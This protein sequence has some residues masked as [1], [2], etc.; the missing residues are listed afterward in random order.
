MT[1]FLRIKP[2]VLALAIVAFTMFG[3]PER[4]A[5]INCDQATLQN[6]INNANSGDTITCNAGSW[7]WTTPVTVTNKSLRIVGA[8][9]DQ[10]NITGNTPNRSPMQVTLRVSDTFF[11]S[12]FTWRLQAAGSSSGIIFVGLNNAAGYPP[13]AM[14][15]TQMKMYGDPLDGVSSGGRYIV[16]GGVYGVIDHITMITTT[17]RGAGN[18]AM[19]PDNPIS[20]SNSYH[21]PIRLGDPNAL[22]IEDCDFQFAF[23]NQ[24]NGAVDH[25]PGARW[26][27]RRNT[28]RNNNIGN[29]GWDSGN[30]GTRSFEVYSNTFV[31]DSMIGGI[32]MFGPRSGTGMVWDNVVKN[33]QPQTNSTGYIDFFTPRY[34]GALTPYGLGGN[35]NLNARANGYYPTPPWG[36][37]PYPGTRGPLTDGKNNYVTGCNPID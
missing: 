35:I 21:V 7:V 8:G 10:T 17:I 26:V 33:I 12:G 25:Y 2:T 24:G 13:V 28:V 11:M 6:A 19:T 27:F 9:I 32:Q 37:L 30:R 31:A 34:Y 14:R 1:E 15:L 18:I 3:M 36:A 4:A 20:T 5:A 16:A 22:Y 23:A 29:H